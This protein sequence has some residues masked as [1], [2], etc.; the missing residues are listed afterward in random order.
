MWVCSFFYRS[1]I[2]LFCVEPFGAMA[3][4]TGSVLLTLYPI[5]QWFMGSRFRKRVPLSRSWLTAPLPR[6]TFYI[7]P[8]S[9]PAPTFSSVGSWG[10]PPEHHNVQSTFNSDSWW[11]LNLRIFGFSFRPLD[12]SLFFR[13]L[14][15]PERLPCLFVLLLPS[16]F[17]HGASQRPVFLFRGA[18]WRPA[19]SPPAVPLGVPL[20]SGTVLLS[21]PCSSSAVPSGV[22]LLVPLRC[23]S[24]SRCLPAR[25]FS[26]SRVP[27]PRCLQASRY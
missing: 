6:S 17:R 4:C 5:C 1:V 15:F 18:F 27:L 24:A 2:S 26:A 25:C 9:G 23:H 7:K 22:P 19:T 10:L 20:S 8:V 13:G 3:I 12:L 11:T 14:I 16:V 21:V